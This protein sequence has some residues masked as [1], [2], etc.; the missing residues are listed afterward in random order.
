MGVVG[1]GGGVVTIGDGVR[2]GSTKGGSDGVA[3]GV[4]TGRSAPSV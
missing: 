1:V 4:G 2:L 3:E